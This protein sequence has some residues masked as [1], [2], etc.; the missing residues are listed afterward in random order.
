MQI[1][2]EVI[3]TGLVLIIGAFISASLELVQLLFLALC[4]LVYILIANCG[5]RSQDRRSGYQSEPRR[6]RRLPPP[7]PSSRPFR[8]S[9]QLPLRQESKVPV[10]A[11]TFQSS[12]FSAQVSELAQLITPSKA[13]ERVAQELAEYAQTI[14][15]ETFPAAQVQGIANADVLR[16]TAFGVA[17]PEMDLVVSCDSESLAAQLQGRLAK[18]GMPKAR[19]DAR[20]I[21]KSAIRACTDILVAEAGFKFRRSAFRCDEPKVTLMGPGTMSVSG[22]H[23]IP[24]DFWV[25]CDTPSYHAALVS[26]CSRLDARTRSLVLLVR[27]WSK[28]RG[29]CHVA[30]GHLA[31][32]AWTLLAIFYMQAGGSRILPPLRG[33]KSASGFSVE[34]DQTT[35]EEH[36]QGEAAKTQSVGDLFRGFIGFYQHSMSWKTE[37]VAVRLGRRDVPGEQL[38][39]H[40][41]PA[42]DGTFE[43][44][45][46]IEDPFE[47]S[48][49]L[50]S[51]LSAEGLRRMREE[52]ARADALLAAKDEA[53]LSELLEPWAPPSERQKSVIASGE[54]PE[55]HNVDLQ[56]ESC[57][58]ASSR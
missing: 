18:G 50:G 6:D 43:V 24:L 46:C 15:R 39:P 23:G 52:L 44:A 19:M 40:F 48:R 16:G 4:C 41:I 35:A 9:T 14:I 57:G 34:A 3:Q 7:R 27:R 11:P 33:T 2:A 58:D 29:V 10:Q 20:K 53:S 30:R 8:P 12:G 36:E 51:G 54:E 17:V 22:G 47:P 49:N 25:N 38:E 26:E 42:S 37:A 13:S 31:P 5:S 45:P 55:P 1:R 28:D 56:P 32:Y 21:Q